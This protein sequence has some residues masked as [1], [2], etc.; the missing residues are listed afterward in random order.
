MA[1]GDILNVTTHTEGW[2]VYVTVEG[3][4]GKQGLLTYDQSLLDVDVVSEGYTNGVLGTVSRNLKATETVRKPAPNELELDEVDSGS[5][6]VIRVALDSIIYNDDKNGG[7]GTSGTDPIANFATGWVTDGVN[8]SSNANV[9]VVNTSTRDYP[10][11]IGQWDWKLLKGGWRRVE[12]DFKVGFVAEHYHHIDSVYLSA[13]GLTSNNTLTVNSTDKGLVTM[14]KS[15]LYGESY[16]LDCPIS[17]FTQGEQIN[18]TAIAYPKIGDESSILNTDNN[19]DI[20][21]RIRGFTTCY[22]VCDKD[23]LL[24]TYA[25]VDGDVGIDASGVVSGNLLTAES[26]PFLTIGGALNAGANVIYVNE[27]TAVLS[28]TGVT[29]NRVNT[30]Y[31]EVLPHP[32]NSNPVL[33]RTSQR[34]YGTNF[35]C[36]SGFEFIGKDWLD[37]SNLDR[38]L[39][40]ENCNMNNSSGNPT[41]GVGYRSKGAWLIGC[42]ISGVEHYKTFSSTRVLYSFTDVDIK[43]DMISQASFCYRGMSSRGYRVEISE[44]ASLESVISFDNLLITHNKLMSIPLSSSSV[45]ALFK[46]SNTV[47]QA[48]VIETT[49]SSVS[50]AISISADGTNTD[51]ENILV[52]NVTQVGQ[53]LNVFYN[54]EGDLPAYRRNCALQNCVIELFNIKSDKFT[55]PSDGKNGGRVGNWEQMYGVGFNDNLYD[56]SSS[57]SFTQDFDGVNTTYYG[58]VDIYAQIPFID[59]AGI[60]GSNLGN[61]NYTLFPQKTNVTSSVKYDLQGSVFTEN[62]IGAIAVEAN[63][64]TYERNYEVNFENLSQDGTVISWFKLLNDNTD[65]KSTSSIDK[66]VTEYN[67]KF[68]LQKALLNPIN[69]DGNDLTELNVDANADGFTVTDEDGLVVKNI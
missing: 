60:K 23:G 4:A 18:L 17:G 9:T 66:T 53:R 55:H 27:S 59:N 8:A 56:G 22:L 57:S 33:E 26:S 54:D 50:P 20:N 28:A 1:L 3:F 51:V 68:G 32:T 7:I 31:A 42:T 67:Y 64:Q 14:D 10:I 11:V 25:V 46:Y 58:S 16:Q 65:S 15:G 34:A 6:L 49:G 47:F 39:L 24:K 19:T 36:Y 40:L 41:V 2:S 62:E 12:N 13:N 44:S 29:I 63:Q 45:L 52:R 5:D 61:G 38:Q 21:D 43:A 37:G 35:L 48:S 30:F 69:W